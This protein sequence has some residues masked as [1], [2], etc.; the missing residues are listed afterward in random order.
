MSLDVYLNVKEMQTIAAGPRIFIREN[1][2]T[3]EIDRAEWDR[4]NPGIEPV[5]CQSQESDRVYQRNITHNLNS[6]ADA[7]G[8]YRELWRPDEI[9]ITIAGQLV[10]PLRAGLA[11]LEADP[12]K[13]RAF[14]PSNGWGDYEG[15]VD[16]VTEYLAA[17]ERWPEAEVQVWR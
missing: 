15:L 1:G 3:L 12:A 7:A 14:N 4:R 11:R 9:G 13:F 17:C 5:T 8:I 16:F 10:E 2:R 6:M